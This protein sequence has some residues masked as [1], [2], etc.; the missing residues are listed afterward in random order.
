MNLCMYACVHACAKEASGGTL[1]CTVASGDHL[2]AGSAVPAANSTGIRTQGPELCDKV[3]E[4]LR[5]LPK[6][7]MIMAS[8]VVWI[9]KT[10]PKTHHNPPGYTNHHG[11]SCNP[12]MSDIHRFRKLC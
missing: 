2:A 7:A 5:A 4:A 9:Q 8:W 10:T 11:N 1:L 6:G 12:S 3:H